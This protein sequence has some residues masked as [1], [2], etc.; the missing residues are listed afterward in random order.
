M[1]TGSQQRYTFSLPTPKENSRGKASR[2]VAMLFNGSANSKCHSGS[3]REERDERETLLGG[4][5]LHGNT[6]V[7]CAGRCRKISVP[8]FITSLLAPS[9]DVSQPAHG[10]AGYLP[11]LS[12][13]ATRFRVETSRRDSSTIVG[14]DAFESRSVGGLS[15]TTDTGRPPPKKNPTRNP[16][17]CYS[18]VFDFRPCAVDASRSRTLSHFS[19]SQACLPRRDARNRDASTREP[20]NFNGHTKKSLP[21]STERRSSVNCCELTRLGSSSL[22]KTAATPLIDSANYSQTISYWPTANIIRSLN[23]RPRNEEN[24]Y[25]LASISSIS[26]VRRL[27]LFQ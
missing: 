23:G 11:N 22:S 24:S 19:S 13:F 21:R 27:P 18:L 9:L 15:M 4:T 3:T 25:R 16:V 7:W 17:R 1:H 20:E 12:N 10:N 6:K 8:G 2:N 26:N 5:M 14:V